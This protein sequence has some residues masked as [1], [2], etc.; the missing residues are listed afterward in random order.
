MKYRIPFWLTVCICVLLS[1]C[2]YDNEEDLYPFVDPSGCDTLSISFSARIMPILESQCT[3]CH[4]GN[5]PAGGQDLTTY[6]NVRVPAG[7]GRLVGV[8]SHADGFP[9]MPRGGD[10]LPECDILAVT[11]WINQGLQDN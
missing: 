1:A 5:F 3:G 4:S 9:N 6:E 7:D 11:A 10:Q 2:Y 8:I